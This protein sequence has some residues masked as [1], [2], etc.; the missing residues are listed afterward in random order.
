[1]LTA[2]SIALGATTFSVVFLA[3]WLIDLRARSLQQDAELRSLRGTLDRVAQ[4]VVTPWSGD[5]RRLLAEAVAAVPNGLDGAANRALESTTATDSSR[6]YRTGAG[7]EPRALPSPL[8]APE[9]SG[10]SA[11]SSAPRQRM[12]PDVGAPLARSVVGGDRGP[13]DESLGV[14]LISGAQEELGLVAEMLLAIDTEAQDT[15]PE[16]RAIGSVL[17]GLSDRLLAGLAL[18]AREGGGAPPPPPAADDDEPPASSDPG[19]GSLPH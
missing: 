12:P 1:M 7:K 5:R 10:D 6:A 8:P 16:P 14:A 15:W 9:A 18:L 13:R 17:R 19:G 4:D 2:L 11:P 3:A